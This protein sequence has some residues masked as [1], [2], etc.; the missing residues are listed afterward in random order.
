MKSYFTN[1]DLPEIFP[2]PN[3]TFWGPRSCEV[4]MKF[5]QVSE[6][7]PFQFILRQMVNPPLGEAAVG[8]FSVGVYA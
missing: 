7:Q 4:A 8:S 2:F 5:D 3:A 1:L 6:H